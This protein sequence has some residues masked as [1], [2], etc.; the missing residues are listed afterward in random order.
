MSIAKFHLREPKN[1]PYLS[2][3][4]GTPE[5]E[6]LQE[7]LKRLKSK[8][9]EIP[10]IIGGKE[11][12]TGNTYDVVSVEKRSRRGIRMMLSVL[13]TMDMSSLKH[14]YVVKKRLKWP[15]RRPRKHSKL[16]PTCRGKSEL[17]SLTKQLI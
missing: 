2:Y 7:E 11:V 14:I 5:R 13:T 15:L 1:E 12:K 3:A 4:P 9:I 6:A 10:A 16:G 17:L 8:T